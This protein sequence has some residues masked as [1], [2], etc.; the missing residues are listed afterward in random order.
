MGVPRQ[1]VGG[2]AL[3]DLVY[4]VGGLSGPT[5][6]AAV[7]A[8]D[9]VS[10]RWR[11]VAPLPIPLHHVAVAAVGGV[12]YSIGGL[13]PDFSGVANV[14]AYDPAADAWT[15]RAPLSA[16]RG[17]AAAAVFDGRIYVAGGLRGGVAVNDFAVY[18]PASGAWTELPLMPHARD[19]LGVAATDLLVYA[20]GGRD[21]GTLFSLCEAFHP[22][23]NQWFKEVAPLL[24]ARGGLAVTALGGR[25][26]AF[27][28]EGNSASPLGVFAET[29]MFDP[30]RNSWFRQPDMPTPRHGIAAV[31][32][33]GRIY[34]V[35]GATQEGYGT[36]GVTEVFLPPSA[37]PLEVRAVVLRR[38]GTRLRLVVR[39]L[40]VA[41]DPAAVPLRVRVRDG[42][43][44]VVSMTLGTGAL[45]AK[46]RGWR[47]RPGTLPTGTSL[48]LR[49]RQALVV[50]LASTTL[51]RPASR[52]GLG[53]VVE[54][55][56]RVFSG[57]V[58]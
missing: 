32:V 31:P 14:F 44:D 41:D 34:V 28:G 5:P 37:D 57:T 24:T 12:L 20:V 42:D 49:R 58:R 27:G 7:E 29:E 36:T 17:A 19:H 21:G 1:E 26:F 50:R 40:D 43:A 56:A 13:A 30:S 46:G 6:S 4:V 54:L 53:V 45:V 15:A 9:T 55:G 22:P 47:P 25:L 3:G 8:Y 10:N 35:G 16:P 33:G 39:L 48:S 2:A 11:S 38:R 51:R 52:H 18:D 23:S